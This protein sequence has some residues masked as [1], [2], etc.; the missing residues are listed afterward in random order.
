MTSINTT[1]AAD[2]IVRLNDARALRN[3]KPVSVKSFKNKQAIADAI[4]ALPALPKAKKAKEESKA[5][6]VAELARELGM[7]PKVARQKL[8]RYIEGP[9]GKG[10]G[11]VNGFGHET[12]ERWAKASIDRTT[13]RAILTGEARR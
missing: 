13:L 8:R 5:S 9:P 12:G 1:T 2:L 7:N 11:L 4:N 3:L 6:P 10:N